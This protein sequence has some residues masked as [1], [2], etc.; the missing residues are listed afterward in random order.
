MAQDT[1]SLNFRLLVMKQNRDGGLVLR[2]E[3]TAHTRFS[4]RENKNLYRCPGIGQ[5]EKVQKAGQEQ[6]FQ[7]RDTWI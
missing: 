7:V 3:Q 4:T 5:G 6:S 2:V 1:S